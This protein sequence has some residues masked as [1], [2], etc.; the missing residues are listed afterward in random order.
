VAAGLESNGT[1]PS[2]S[3]GRRSS[4]ALAKKNGST[5]GL[6]GEEAELD[7][8]EA[9]WRRRLDSSAWHRRRLQRWPDSFGTR[10]RPLAELGRFRG[11]EEERRVGIGSCGGV[12]F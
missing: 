4:P 2:S 9:E 5:A 12:V 11:E 6:G 8:D 7:G 3:S 1:R 10:R